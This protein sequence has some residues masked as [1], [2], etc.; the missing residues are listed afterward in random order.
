MLQL[1][2]LLGSWTAVGNYTVQVVLLAGTAWST[3]FV[4]STMSTFAVSSEYVA[5]TAAPA[6][7]VRFG[8]ASPIL[9][10]A[11]EYVSNTAV[12]LVPLVQNVNT[13]RKYLRTFT[14]LGTQMGRTG[15]P[16]TVTL[17]LQ[18]GGWAE[19][20]SGYFVEVVLLREGAGWD[21]RF[22]RSG[23]STFSVS[24]SSNAVGS[25]EATTET[26]AAGDSGTGE[27]KSGTSTGVIVTLALVAVAC[28]ALA[29]GVGMAA[30]WRRTRSGVVLL[31][32]LDDTTPCTRAFTAETPL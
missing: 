5:F 4:S 27:T 8:T 21:S 1:E 24:S 20:G 13:T 2:G 3:R 18:L 31:S 23:R 17:R 15:D 12:T 30:R 29:V 6:T 32:E 10:V 22:A 25:A 7:V 9:D 11:I 16:T 28:V 26:L 14:V 19:V